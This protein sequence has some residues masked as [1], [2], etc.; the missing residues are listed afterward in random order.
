MNEHPYYPAG[1][2]IKMID[3]RGTNA[4]ELNDFLLEYEGFILNIYPTPMPSLYN[5][6]RFTIVYKAFAD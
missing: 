3:V 2:Q 6:T 1:T 5:I 4:E